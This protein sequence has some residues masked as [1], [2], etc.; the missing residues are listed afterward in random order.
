MAIAVALGIASG[1]FSHGARAQSLPPDIINCTRVQD[2]LMRLECFDRAVA[3]AHPPVPGAGAAPAAAKPPAPEHLRAK[4]VGVT[5]LTDDARVTLDN[6]Q[7]WEQVQPAPASLDLH[8]GVTISID[9]VL[10][11]YWLSD[12][13]GASMKVKERT[14]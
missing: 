8:A 13:S 4:V 1:F 11:G 12:A 14:P 9:R 10:G 6:G 5:A 2:A 7:V 3:A